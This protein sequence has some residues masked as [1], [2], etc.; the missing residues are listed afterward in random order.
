[1][2]LQRLAGALTGIGIA[3]VL[4]LCLGARAAAQGGPVIEQIQPTSGPPGTL[5]NIVGRHFG[6]DAKASLGVQPLPIVES[7]PNRITVRIPAGLQSGNIAVTAASGTVRG[8]EF[9]LVPA[10]PAPE[11]DSVD[12]LSGPPGTHVVIRG[13]HFSPLLTGNVVT[14]A[15]QPIVVLS[16][17]PQRLEVIVSD[18]KSGGP[19]AVR[20]G[21]AGEATS[22]QSFAL[23]AATTI[24]A[25]E[26]M[27][28]APG[29]QLTIHGQGFSK[30]SA[31]DR[32]Y[33]NSVPLRVKS[34]SESELVVVLPLKVAS[35]KLLVDVR[36]AGRAYSA[37]P[38]VIQRPPS[39][40]AFEPKKGPP[41]TVI[42]VRGTNFGSAP[43]AIEAKLGDAQLHVR[44]ARDTRLELDVPEGA[45]DGKLSIRVHGVGPAWSSQ[46]FAVLPVLRVTNFSPQS[47]PAGSGIA[48]EGQGFGDSPARVRASVAGRPARVLEVSPT[49]LRLRVPKGRS[50]PLEVRV[51]GSGAVSTTDPFVVTVP[52]VIAA[53]TPE[54]GAVGTEVTIQGSGFGINPAVPK[55]TLGDHPLTVKSV[56]DDRLVVRVAPGA[57]SGRL[58]VAIPLQ[59]EV[60]TDWVF[61]VLP[62]SP[63]PAAAPA[64]QTAAH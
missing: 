21:Q 19:F 56:R 25:V 49:R 54:K 8:P 51:A 18:V 4:P 55:V 23:S 10:S 5:V 36:D 16:A 48:V 62:A 13:Q 33:L 17:A 12:P 9:R 1:M 39:I 53:V 26:P 30:R 15:G 44:D 61:E 22:K 60:E 58:K 57:Q 42:T 3:L 45:K 50:G 6:P 32:V 31:D 63:A 52:P 7:L 38:F 2:S 46:D 40:V 41:G 34:A 59:G 28:G 24:S 20:V 14:L 37:E 35:G 11:I 43:D 64:S 29:S 47:G 27:R